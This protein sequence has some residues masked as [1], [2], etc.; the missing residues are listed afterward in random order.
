MQHKS[1]LRIVHGPLFRAP[2]DVS[3]RLVCLMQNA[4][5]F[6]SEIPS[7]VLEKEDAII[8]HSC[9]GHVIYCITEIP[10]IQQI[11]E[12]KDLICSR[13]AGRNL[14]TSIL[15]MPECGLAAK[16]TGPAYTT[17]GLCDFAGNN[18]FRSQPDTLQKN[19]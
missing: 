12:N 6:P 9:L 8:F 19:I 13:E 1:F 14:C 2:S 11:L 15:K 5:N 4:Q 10:E 16:F 7:M 18:G 17:E 3:R